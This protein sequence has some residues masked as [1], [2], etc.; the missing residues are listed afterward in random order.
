MTL[1]QYLI[2]MSVIAALCW[3]TWSYIA[4]AVNPEATNWF[5]FLLFYFSL[6]LALAGTAT[7]VGFLVRFVALKK[8]LAFRL[9]R[10]AFRQSFLFASLIIISLMLLSRGLFSWLNL[11]LLIIGLSALEFFLLNLQKQGKHE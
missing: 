4:W 10:E 8:E 9:V 2:T 5:G 11:L 6:F 3:L 1:K 7:V